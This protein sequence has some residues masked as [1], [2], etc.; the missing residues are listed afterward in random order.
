M[1]KDFR[2]RVNVKNNAL[3]EAIES[4]GYRMGQAFCAKAGVPYWRISNLVALR[5]SPI[6]GDMRWLPEVLKLCD[7]LGR[8]PEEV[9]RPS[10][11]RALE[12]NNAE[13]RLDAEE[14]FPLLEALPDPV[15]LLENKERSEAIDHA[16]AEHLSERER[17][18]VTRCVM[19][20]EL[21]TDLAVEY[22]L[23]RNRLSQIK[24]K[25]LGKLRRHGGLEWAN[26]A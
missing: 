26:D 2:V 1:S 9:F 15:A 13:R 7:F 19:G 12:K 10:H 16:L 3:L 20:S 17:D 23:S 21:L 18:V 25:A 22:G 8:D 24:D 4:A 5:E 14:V 11:L 6:G